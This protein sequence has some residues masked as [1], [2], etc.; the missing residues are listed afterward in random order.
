M[1]S[2]WS[3]YAV[4]EIDYIIAT[5]D[6]DGAQ[7]HHDRAA[8]AAEIAAFSAHTRFEKLD[9]RDAPPADEDRGEVR[10]HA[11]LSRDGR[12]VSFVERSEFIRR[13]GRWLYR[14]PLED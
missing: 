10:F 4:G 13:D 6:P 3:A 8:W 2:R 14:Q 9:I 5:T 11:K 7:A 1:R 12:D